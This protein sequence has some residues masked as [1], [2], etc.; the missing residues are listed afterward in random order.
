[1][2]TGRCLL[3]GI[4]ADVLWKIPPQ[5]LQNLLCRHGVFAVEGGHLTHGMNTGIRSATAA[6][7]NFFSQNAGK[8]LFQLPLN[9]IF[10]AGQP[11]PTA[12]AA[13]IIA[14]LKAQVPHIP[15]IPLWL[16]VPYPPRTGI[17]RIYRTRR[18]DRNETE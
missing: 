2:E 14:H 11:L 5:L 18:H 15:S 1:M 9:G 12:V 17:S 10:S 7:F 6:Y 8:G 4:Y 13:A 3:A 16:P